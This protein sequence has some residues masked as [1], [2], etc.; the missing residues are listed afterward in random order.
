[1]ERKLS[2]IDSD[3]IEFIPVDSLQKI[4]M[5][6]DPLMCK[7]LQKIEGF[8]HGGYN[9]YNSQYSIRKIDPYRVTDAD[10]AFP[11]GDSFLVYPGED[12]NAVESLRLLVLEEGFEDCRALKLLEQYKGK[13]YVHNLVN[14]IAGMNITFE[15]YP[16]ESESF[17][18]LRARINKELD[19]I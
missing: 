7:K 9:Y 8:L 11:S 18:N 14:Q 3:K 16:V 17:E 1:M 6:K 19:E 10:D 12:G 13:K 15:K 4:F 5:K 2:M